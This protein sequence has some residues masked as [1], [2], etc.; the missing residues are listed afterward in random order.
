MDGKKVPLGRKIIVVSG[1]NVVYDTVRSL[2]KL[3]RAEFGNVYI[4]IMSLEG[5]CELPADD[6]EIEEGAVE[7]VKL[8]P[9]RS[10]REFILDDKGNLKG[11]KTVFCT[12]VFDASGKFNPQCDISD[13]EIYETDMIVEAIGQR[14]DYSLLGKYKDQLK[15]ITGRVAVNDKGQTSLDWLFA[16]GDIGARTGHHNS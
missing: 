13:I 2:A 10:P 9:L 7:G 1:G 12:C 3:Q 4:T 14:T 11:V 6:E 15:F 5:E 16:G 8:N